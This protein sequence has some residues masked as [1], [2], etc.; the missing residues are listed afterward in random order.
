VNSNTPVCS[1]ECQR[2]LYKTALRGANNPNYKNKWS[3]K[4]KQ[5]QS[6][7]VKSKVNDEY[8]FKAGTAN[9]GK[10]SLNN[11]FALCMNIVT[12]NRIHTNIQMK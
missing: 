6:R 4:Q 5:E 11:A 1:K 9:R 12:L 7:L 8:R 10:N 2:I 3:L